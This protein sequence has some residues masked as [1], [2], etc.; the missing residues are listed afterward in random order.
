MTII[1]VLVLTVIYFLL[2][3]AGCV[4]VGWLAGQ[5]QDEVMRYLVAIVLPALWGA[6]T[7]QVYIFK[8]ADL[9]W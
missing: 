1:K 7:T 3:V 2:L 6:I 8:L 4:L 5:L 9:L